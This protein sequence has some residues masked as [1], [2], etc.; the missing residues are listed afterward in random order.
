[1]TSKTSF[2]DTKTHTKITLKENFV[3]FIPHTHKK[4][5]ITKYSDKIKRFEYARFP[6]PYKR[7]N[8]DTKYVII[9]IGGNTKN[10]IKNFYKLIHRLKYKNDI[11]SYSPFLKNPA[12]GYEKQEDFYN[13]VI[14]L[15]TNKCYVDFFSFCMYLERI[16]GRSRKRPFKNAPRTLDIDILG[17]K[18]IFV[19]LSHLH[20]PHKEWFKRESVLIPLKGL[21]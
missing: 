2:W 6:N 1:M 4:L 12:F 19:N 5:Q 18:N 15:K 14:V 3:Y 7:M 10:V 9:G 17:F 16:F 11:I 20:I 21:K 13:G 8:I